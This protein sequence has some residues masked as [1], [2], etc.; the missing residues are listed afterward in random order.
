MIEV[1]YYTLETGELPEL[2]AWANKHDLDLKLMAINGLA[3]AEDMFEAP[4]A[5]Q[6]IDFV[7]GALVE[8][9]SVKD[10]LGFGK[11]MIVTVWAHGAMHDV[12]SDSK[13]TV[14]VAVIVSHDA[15]IAMGERL[16]Q[17]ETCGRCNRHFGPQLAQ[18]VHVGC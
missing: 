4:S 18:P 5:R 15:L 3:V 10:D 8:G 2:K 17:P 1:T 7:P 16:P 11:S 6:E 12:N 14:R 9:V 13:G